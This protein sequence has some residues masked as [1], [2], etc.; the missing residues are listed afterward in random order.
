VDE[1][2]ADARLAHLTAVAPW[3]AVPDPKRDVLEE[4]VREACAV[5]IDVHNA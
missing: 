5:P 2:L 1:V 4:A 3:L